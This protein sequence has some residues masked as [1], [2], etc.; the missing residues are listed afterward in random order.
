MKHTVATYAHLLDVAQWRL[1]DVAR[2]SAARGASGAWREAR[3]G[4]M[5]RGARH[6]VHVA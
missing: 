1:V 2:E 3:A 5:A 6:G 4:C